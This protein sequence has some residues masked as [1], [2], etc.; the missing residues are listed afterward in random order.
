MTLVHQQSGP[1][2]LGRSGEPVRASGH[3]VVSVW[4]PGR[5]VNLAGT[6]GPLRRGRTDP[7][8]RFE[9]DGI[10]RATTTP[11]GSA[12]LRLRAVEA[13]G[14]VEIAGWG[15]GAD[16]AV[17]QAPELLGATDDWPDL[18]LAGHPE[19]VRVRR[20]RPGLRLCRTRLIWEAIAPAILEQKVV[21]LDAWLS[22]RQLLRRFGTP[23]PGPAPAG[24]LMCP[25]AADWAR[26]PSWEFHRAGVDPQRAATAMRAARLA[27]SLERLA[28][29][30]IGRPRVAGGPRMVDALRSIQGVGAWTAAEVVQRALGD[31]DTVSVGDFHLPAHVGWVLAGREVDDAGMLELLEPWR[32]HRQ[33]VVRLVELCG[34][35]PP[36]RGPRMSRVDHRQL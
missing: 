28:A 21:G 9:S 34:H 15:P 2:P 17:G 16:W 32:G 13:A 33:R 12:T 25:T 1:A 22:W 11:Q 10:W 4:R 7:T 30:P 5:P 14:E 26:I 36:R 24:M 35:R 8:L 23:A 19:L 31:P 20:S 3:P 18:E 6:L 29:E 27:D